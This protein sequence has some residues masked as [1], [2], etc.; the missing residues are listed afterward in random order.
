[1][2]GT[3]LAI[4]NQPAVKM[5]QELSQTLAQSIN[6][7]HA[8]A[9]IAASTARQ[10]IETAITKA[11]AAGVLV[12][13]AAGLYK[14]GMHQ[15]LRENVPN[16]SVEQA[17]RYRGIYKVRSKRDCLEADTRQLRLIGILGDSDTE[18]G[19]SSTAQRA[20]GDRW[21]KWVGHVSH[22]FKEVE[23]TRPIEQWEAFERRA[24][25][26]QLKPIVALY[27]KAGGL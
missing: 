25:A 23:T 13:E 6:E 1:M 15:W 17:E 16:L 24:L 8:E 20:S 5:N 12:D 22:Y 4:P 27:K 2:T 10:D 7:A 19:A 9:V 14:S 21:I 3:R 11:E 18:E 26:E